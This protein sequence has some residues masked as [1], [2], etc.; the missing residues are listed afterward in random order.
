MGKIE[1]SWEEESG[2]QPAE[3]D[4]APDC[5]TEGGAQESEC[6]LTD[7]RFCP[8]LNSVISAQRE[9]KTLGEDGHV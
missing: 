9:E 3:V 6:C 5:V 8:V 2:V 1:G 7:V 4:Q